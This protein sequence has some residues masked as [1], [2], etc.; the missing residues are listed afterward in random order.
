MEPYPVVPG[1]GTANI[2]FDI[3]GAFPTRIEGRLLDAT[4]GHT[5]SRKYVIYRECYAD[6]IL[7]P[8]E[9]AIGRTQCSK[10]RETIEPFDKYCS[11]CGA[12]IKKRRLLK[13]KADAENIII[14]KPVIDE[15][16]KHDSEKD[17]S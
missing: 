15:E 9:C 8:D 13:K 5:Q 6:V 11:H 16:T 10:C 4:T 12:K 14:C 17:P 3:D 2:T 7:D 1:T